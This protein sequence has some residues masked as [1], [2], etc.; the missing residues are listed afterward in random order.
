MLKEICSNKVRNIFYNR[1]FFITLSLLIIQCSQK[2]DPHLLPISDDKD[3]DYLI[4]GVESKVYLDP[5][6]PDTD[7]D[8]TLDGPQLAFR[9]VSR[10]D[11]LPDT[12]Q[13]QCSYAIKTFFT[14]NDTCPV[15]GE[16]IQK[17]E[18]KVVD[19]ICNVTCIVPLIGL[20]FLEKGSFRYKYSDGRICD[21]DVYDLY[22]AAFGPVDTKI[23][24]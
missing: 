9:L 1:F 19:P 21:I 17:G 5:K 11:S 3:N 22:F 20:H 24:P 16:E 8:G 18:I 14:G 7:G 23:I 12:V 4:D 15:C 10:I 13:T 6:N 2:A